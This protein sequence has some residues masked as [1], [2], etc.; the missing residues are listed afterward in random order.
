MFKFISRMLHYLW[1]FI[2]GARRVATNLIL[3]AIIVAVIAAIV[4]PGPTVPKG[5]AALYVRPAGTLVEQPTFN[6]SLDF[7]SSEQQKET[8]LP[9]LLEAIRAA[10]DDARIKLLVLE[11]DAIDAGGLAKFGELRA[12]INDFK[13]SG[14]PVLA[15]GERFNQNQYYLASV[16]DEVHLDPDGFVLL[17]GLARFTTYFRGA[18]DKL[19][20]KVH[21]FR[22]G[23][24]KS[25]GEPFTRSDM[26]EEDREATRTLLD[27]LWSRI[28]DEISTARKLDPTQF[29]HYVLDY[30][31]KLKTAKGDPA[32]A[33]QSA[34][35]IDRF[36]TRDQWKALIKERLGDESADKDFRHIDADAYLVAVRRAN[37]KNPNQIAVLVA[38]GAIVDGEQPPGAVG[39]DSFAQLI[40]EAREDKQVKALVIR[41]DSPGGSAGASEVIRRE[42]ELTR[43]AGKPVIASMSSL[44][45]SGGYWIAAGADEIYA[46]PA[47]LTGSI[48]VFGI[49]PEFSKPLDTLGLSVDGVATAPLAGALDPRRPLDPIVAEA[50]QLGIGHIYQRFLDIVAKARK[51]EPDA[52]DKIARGRVWSGQ[53]AVGLGLVDYVGGID[54]ALA[55]AAS[56]AKLKSYTVTWPMQTIPPMQLL[57]K[58]LFATVGNGSAAPSPASTIVKRLTADFK[59]LALWND[60]HHIYMHCLCEMP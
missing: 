31:D 47:T 37:P 35:L 29:D 43:Q 7:F 24:Y 28:R 52:V 22:A 33:A 49:F 3:L 2:D 10:R 4:H 36:S 42:L 14:K 32:V 38:Q 41:I 48:G 39:G 45:A 6:P 1:S 27:G 13:T 12:A 18:L 51:M 44:A 9:D 30:L 53:E 50:L 23:E 58:R 21:L 34:G 54:A 46:E 8:V 19:G 55:G 15:R 17:Q 5:G 56:R 16:A 40:R 59:S 60:P 25:F 26:S 11:T 57:L 20:V